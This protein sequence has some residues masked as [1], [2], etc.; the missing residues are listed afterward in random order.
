MPVLLLPPGFALCAYQ[1]LVGNTIPCPFGLF[2]SGD[3]SWLDAPAAIPRGVGVVAF[4]EQAASI[5]AAVHSNAV[6]RLSVSAFVELDIGGSISM[7]V[8][9]GASRAQKCPG[10]LPVGCEV[11][12][13][14]LGSGRASVS[15]Q[16]GD[17]KSQRSPV[18]AS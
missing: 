13:T 1:S 3:T 11:G 9:F 6:L 5:S 18:N 2:I 12:Q 17:Y 10:S 4:S 7:G 15:F 8:G 16:T 14:G